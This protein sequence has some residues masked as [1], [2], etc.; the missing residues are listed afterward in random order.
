MINFIGHD[1][2]K[3]KI[4]DVQRSV[5]ISRG[6]LE[7]FGLDSD[8]TLF[9]SDTDDGTSCYPEVG[10]LQLLGCTGLK[11][12]AGSLIYE[13]D[14]L[15]CIS[16]YYVENGIKPI[17]RVKW[18]NDCFAYYFW[19]ETHFIERDDVLKIIG[20]IYESPELLEA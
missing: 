20:N 8:G 10:S 12:S 13:G 16:P 17:V 15:E 9:E 11:D 2:F 3:F 18:D 4:W 6:D 14:I 1:R 19:S 5:M 7:L